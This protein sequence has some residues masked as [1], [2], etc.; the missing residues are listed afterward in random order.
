MY[1]IA[2]LS[3][4]G[5]VRVEWDPSDSSSVK[6]AKAEFSRLKKAGFAF[7]TSDDPTAPKVAVSDLGNPRLSHASVYARMVQ[8]ASFGQLKQRTIARPP[9]RGG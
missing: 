3:P 6:R 4:A 5:H 7:F 9:M 1:E 2:V 8:A